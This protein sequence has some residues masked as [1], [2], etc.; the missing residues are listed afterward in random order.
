M[1]SSH[2]VCEVFRIFIVPLAAVLAGTLVFAALLSPLPASA[3]LYD[4]DATSAKGGELKDRDYWRARWDSMRLDEAIQERQPEGAI[5]MEVIGQERLLDD[6]LKKY[7]NDE[8]FKKWKAHAKEIKAKIDPDA[9]RSEEFKPG[10]LWAEGDYKEAYVNY[11][12]AKVAMQEQDWQEAQ[13]GLRYADQKLGYLRKRIKDNDRINAWPQ[14]AAQW[15]T[16]TS[17]EVAKM[18]QEV[19]AKLK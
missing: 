7:P 3:G 12:Y 4:S 2:R 17:A 8:D 16:D 18:Q 15:V 14:G 10:S 11:N 6:L 19:T 13:D 9:N 5:L 1:D